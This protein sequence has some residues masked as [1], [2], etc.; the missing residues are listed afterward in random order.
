MHCLPVASPPN[1]STCLASC[2]YVEDQCTCQC[3]HLLFRFSN[4]HQNSLPFEPA[5][6]PIPTEPFVLIAIDKTVGV[7][8]AWSREVSTTSC[9]LCRL[10]ILVGNLCSSCSRSHESTSMACYLLKRRIL[11]FLD[12][13]VQHVR[14]IVESSFA[15]VYS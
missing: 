7:F 13:L 11:E 8:L 15:T 5:F 1:D 10:Q 6:C 14:M 2:N 4:A 12:E 3:V 9:G